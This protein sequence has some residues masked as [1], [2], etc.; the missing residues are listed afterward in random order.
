[1]GNKAL[2]DPWMHVFPS[3]RDNQPAPLKPARPERYVAHCLNT[4]KATLKAA[5]DRGEALSAL[6]AD[7]AGVRQ[8]GMAQRAAAARSAARQELKD[9][10]KGDSVSILRET[11]E[12]AMKEA[13]ETRE[14]LNEVLKRRTGEFDPQE[15]FRKTHD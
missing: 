2:T 3:L 14:A 6:H 12:T 8:A 9:L 4:L 11:L 5:R 1:M 15:S 7:R 10:K 13:E